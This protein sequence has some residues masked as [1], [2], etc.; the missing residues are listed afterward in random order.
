MKWWSNALSWNCIGGRC[1]ADA[2][3][4]LQRF[5]V[6]GLMPAR[7]LQFRY[8]G[9][10]QTATLQNST[11]PLLQAVEGEDSGSTELAE[12]LPA[13][14]LREGGTTSSRTI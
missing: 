14:A 10:I 12:V 13:I 3:W 7:R 4:A 2:G 1:V 5:F 6:A 9:A 11:T 8:S